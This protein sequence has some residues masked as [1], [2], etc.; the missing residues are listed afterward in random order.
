VTDPRALPRRYENSTALEEISEWLTKI[1]VGLGLI[2]F[3][4]IIEKLNFVAGRAAPL[5]AE[6]K[7]PT[8]ALAIITMAILLTNFLL[9]F[10]AAYIFTRMFLVSAFYRVDVTN[11]D[12]LA[13]NNR[14]SELDSE[15]VFD[16]DLAL[17]DQRS[18]A[19][20]LRVPF[21]SLRT[22]QDYVAWA[23]AHLIFRDYLPAAEALKRALDGARWQDPELLSLYARTLAAQ[24]NF[25]DSEKYLEM[26]LT[27]ARQTDPSRIPDIVAD[28]IDGAL[29]SGRAD[30]LQRARK[31]L[32]ELLPNDRAVP[33]LL[34][35]SAALAAQEFPT[36]PPERTEELQLTITNS[37]KALR[38]S[39]DE[40]AVR[41]FSR[42]QLGL[43][44]QDGLFR[45]GLFNVM[46]NV[47]GISEVT[48][49]F[50]TANREHAL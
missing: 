25:G 20:L 13:N 22:G 30:D 29:A 3:G 38:E 33:R 46:R 16:Q 35:L 9:G 19:E 15:A 42:L 28:Q 49:L 11:Q 14:I 23:K 40:Q 50:N 24:R 31:R 1:I 39:S 41:L 47:A 34:A 17:G 10:S 43:R 27:L 18:A 12:L 36:A 48:D 45:D 44:G 8:D 2:E 4:T 37:I 5:F 32:E 21:T 7:L 6:T 26:A